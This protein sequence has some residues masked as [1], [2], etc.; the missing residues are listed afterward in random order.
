MVSWDICPKGAG[1]IA[2]SSKA[3]RSKEPLQEPG[4]H[5]L[6]SAPC[7]TSRPFALRRNSHS[8]EAFVMSDVWV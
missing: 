7:R 8:Q 6:P 1:S 5:S 2:D 3:P 4:V